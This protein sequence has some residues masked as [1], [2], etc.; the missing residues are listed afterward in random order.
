MLAI[1]P[2]SGFVGAVITPVVPEFPEA[3]ESHGWLN[4]FV[5]SALNWILIRSLMLVFLMIEKSTLFV[6]CT[7]RFEDLSGNVRTLFA[8][9]NELSRLK[10]VGLAS[11]VPGQVDE[12]EFL[13]GSL[14]STQMGF[15]LT[16]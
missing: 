14:K 10:P 9:W 13:Q 3:A 5:N 1:L 7:R 4:A 15:P 8:S 11:G 2:K 12:K 6:G 16:V